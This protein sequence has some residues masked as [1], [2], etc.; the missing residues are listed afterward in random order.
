MIDQIKHFRYVQPFAPFEL[1]LSSGRRIKVLT[2]DHLA[3]DRAGTGRVVFL[4]Y[5]GTFEVVSGLHVVSVGQLKP[6][7]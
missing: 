6:S 1:E 4:D 2:P 5:D 7:S 3:F